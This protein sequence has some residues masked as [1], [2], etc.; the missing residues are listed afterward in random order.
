MFCFARNFKL[1]DEQMSTMLYDG[2][3]ATFMED[4]EILE[5][6]QANVNGGSID[7]MVDITNDAA[8]LQ[9]RRI[10]RNLMAAERSAAAQ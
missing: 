3:K 2:S 6:Q 4:V 5:L 1:G 8:Q 10:M 9:A 7:G